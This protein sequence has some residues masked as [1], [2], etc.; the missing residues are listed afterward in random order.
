MC[1][2]QLVLQIGTIHTQQ[3]LVNDKRVLVRRSLNHTASHFRPSKVVSILLSVHKSQYHI[4]PSSH[5]TLVFHIRVRRR[6]VYGHIVLA[7]EGR[8]LSLAHNGHGKVT[9][10]RRRQKALHHP[11]VA[12]PHIS[13]GAQ[14]IRTYNFRQPRKLRH[15]VGKVRVGLVRMEPIRSRVVRYLWTRIVEHAHQG[16]V[17][18]QGGNKLG[19]ALACRGHVDCIWD[20]SDWI[21]L[22]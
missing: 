18:F 10:G 22:L 21:T 12:T 9:P 11:I 6:L 2:D 1:L 20:F 15:Y 4:T 5:F 17:S 19:Q 14:S 3:V 13:N 16:W 7:K 8:D